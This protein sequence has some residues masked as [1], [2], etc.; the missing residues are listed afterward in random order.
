MEIVLRAVVVFAFLFLVTR[1]VGR[2]SLSE[3]TPFELLIYVTMGDL[4]QQ[5]V[6]QQDF[7]L[8]SAFLA[9]GV[10]ALLTIGLSYT[11]WKWPRL[12]PLIRGTPV[13]LIRSGAVLDDVMRAQRLTMDDLLAAAR[14]Q[15]IRRLSDVDVAVLETDGKI[16]FFQHQEASTSSDDSSGAADKPRASE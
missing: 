12:R 3:I 9:V 2:A 1:V 6:T 8:T 10:F 15:G 13:M 16:S 5:S 4:I 7:S 11:S 14:E